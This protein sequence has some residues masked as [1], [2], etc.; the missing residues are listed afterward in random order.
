MRFL[1]WQSEDSEGDGF[2]LVSNRKAKRKKKSSMVRFKKKVESSK[3][4]PLEGEYTLEEGTSKISSGYNIREK[5][6]SNYKRF[7]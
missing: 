7:P 3:P 6:V 4:P 2:Q 1:E 5:R